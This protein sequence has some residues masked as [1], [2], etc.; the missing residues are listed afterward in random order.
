[1]LSAQNAARGAALHRPLSVQRWPAWTAA[2]AGAAALVGSFLPLSHRSF[3]HSSGPLHPL[4]HLILFG[5][6]AWLSAWATGS[7]NTRALL[8]LCI[9]VL[10]CSTELIEWRLYG[11]PLEY[12]DMIV[13]AIGAVLGTSLGALTAPLLRA[14]AYNEGS[15]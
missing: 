15:R 2:L 9:A 3:F 4:V 12:T 7:A 13:D 6:I 14:H 10:G 5:A 8:C 1:M 11:N